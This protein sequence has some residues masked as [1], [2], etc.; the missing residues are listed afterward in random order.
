LSEY[1]R[2][3]LS[4]ELL[5]FLAIEP[6]MVVVDAT[7][8]GG[9]HAEAVLGKMEGQGKLVGIDRDADAIAAAA[10]RLKR[11]GAAVNLIHGKFSE[12]SSLLDSAGVEKADRIYF[13][14]GVSSHQ[15]DEAERGF[16]F[17]KDA[18][19]DMRMDR[20]EGETAADLLETLPEGKLENIFWEYGEER[21]AR[22]VAK[23]IVRRR[24]RKMVPGRTR[25][26]AE[27]LEAVIGR[28]GQ[29]VHPATRIFQALRIAV[30]HEMEEFFKGL[31]SSLQRL[32]PGGRMA[33]ISYHSLE[34][35]MVKNFFRDNQ[36]EGTLRVLTKKPVRPGTG[37]V[38]SNPRCRSARLRAAERV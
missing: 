33:A 29:R 31:G 36:R 26:L 9:G 24:E 8:G 11:F 18:P 14:L 22:R 2:P 4:A 34:D 5:E 7:V 28:R 21:L 15:F 13:D 37:E 27:L 38:R 35:R 16:S 19:L 3:A 30:N 10:G 32:K 1:H 25:D 23:E 6:G 20:S 12:L 17:S